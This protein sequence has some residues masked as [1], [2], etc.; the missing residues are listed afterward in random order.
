MAKFGEQ[1]AA[2]AAEHYFLR[3]GQNE[4]AAEKFNAVPFLCD[5]LLALGPCFNALRNAVNGV[6]TYIH[7]SAPHRT[8]WITWTAEC[9]WG[10]ARAGIL[11]QPNVGDALR[12]VC[13][14]IA[15]TLPS[16]SFEASRRSVYTILG[17]TSELVKEVVAYHH[18]HFSGQDG[19]APAQSFS[20][21]SRVARNLNTRQRLMYDV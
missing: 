15:Q 2:R 21:S 3:S 5:Q 8:T 4:S 11:Q 20:L 12:A 19:S 6:S 7:W 13:A 1:V 14:R 17:G 16:V 18:D 10:L 9:I